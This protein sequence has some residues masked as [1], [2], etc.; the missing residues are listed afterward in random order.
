MNADMAAAYVGET[1]AKQ[2]LARIGTEYPRPSVDDGF[3]KGR[4]RLWLKRD[5]DR[6]IGNWVEGELDPPLEDF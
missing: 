6:A 2:F 4:R 1:N 5:L 3:G